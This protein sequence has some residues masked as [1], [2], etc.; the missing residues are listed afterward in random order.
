VRENLVMTVV[1]RRAMIVSA[2][3]GEG[4]NAA[5]R[6][7]GETMARTWPGCEVRWLD[8]L[9]AMGP[10]FAPLARGWYVSQIQHL[11]WMYEFFFSAM[12]RHHWYLESTRRG[13]GSLFGRRMA[14][15]IRAFNPDVI[16]ST[17]PLGSAGLSWLRRRGRLGLPVGAWVPA[18]CPHP[19]WLYRNLDITYVMH[20]S[21]AEV[22]A[23]AEP[24]IRVAVGALPVRDAFAPGGRVAAR[25]RLGVDPG[26]FT[27]LLCT[28]S[29]AFGRVHHAVTALL[30]A[31]P[32]I[33]VVVVCGKN[34][35]LR[36]EL[37]ERGAA[38]SRLRVLGWTD[39]MPGWMTASDIVVGNA[40]GA[41]GLEAVASGRPVIMF[42]PIAGHG[43]ANAR[44][45][46]ASG[47]ALLAWSPGELTAV[48]RQLAGDP[49]AVARLADVALARATERRR[50]QDLAELAAL[51]AAYRG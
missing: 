2:D 28:G 10:G 3:V 45:M 9:A 15:Q 14:P 31:G 8:T 39:D 51:G 38:E 12:W 21:A 1:P 5:G 36:G 47:L 40:G 41:T 11:P 24:G 19:S 7:L 13:L 32:A 16:V 18:F 44:L 23:R 25:A 4:H 50:E 22:A 49:G 20:P 46:A 29:F 48:V 43:R 34:Q 6:A 37:A 17:Y 42:E 33:Q 26:Q 35:R 27:V 30:A